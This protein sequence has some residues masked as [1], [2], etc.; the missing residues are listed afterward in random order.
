VTCSGNIAT[1]APTAALAEGK[2][3]TATV[4]TGAKDA[5]GNALAANYT[6]SFTT[7]TT[8]VVD[9]TAP[10]VKSVVPA[11]NGTS[12][13]VNSKV[14]V[15]FSE[16]MNSAT[17]TTGTITLKQG[18]TAVAGTVGYSASVA[19]FTPSSALAAVPHTLQR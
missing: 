19:T 4:T 16:A 14:S 10:T 13:A 5:A 11:V 9:V 1:F 15:T 2:I 8:A 7:I 18:T 12:V 17:I 6:W 3:Y